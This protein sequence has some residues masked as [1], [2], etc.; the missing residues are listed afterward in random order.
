MLRVVIQFWVLAVFKMRPLILLT[1]F[2]QLITFAQST[3]AQ[4]THELAPV[5]VQSELQDED[6]NSAHL[7]ISRQEIEATKK[8]NLNAL[9]RGQNGVLLSQT[10]ASTATGITIGGASGGLGL[11]TLD[12]VPL[13]ATVTSAYSLHH[14]LSDFVDRI[15]IQR[16]SSAQ[17]S[18][19]RTL[20]GA[21]HLDSRELK[22]SEGYA[23]FEAGNY[24]AVRGGLGKGWQTPVGD[25][26]T[27]L[28]RQEITDGYSQASP[29]KGNSESDNFQLNTGL[30][31][32]R[33]TYNKGQ[34]DA[35]LLYSRGREEFDGPGFL[36][37][38]RLGWMD[39]SKGLGYNQTW[40]AQGRIQHRLTGHWQ[41]SLQ[42]A[43]TRNRQDVYTSLLPYTFAAN[44][45]LL[46]WQNQHDLNQS[47]SEQWA[48]RLNWGVDLQQQ[49]GEAY[50]RLGN[51]MASLNT[52]SAYLQNQTRWQ[53]WQLDA[54]TRLEDYQYYGSQALF[55]AKLAWNVFDGVQLWVSGGTGSSPPAV[56]DR[57]NPMFGR[58]SLRPERVASVEVGGRWQLDKDTHYSLNFSHRDYQQLIVLQFDSPTGS[59]RADNVPKAEIWMLEAEGRHAWNDEWQTGFN[60]TFM[61]AQNSLTGLQVAIRPQHQGNLWQAWQ[62]T[63]K[64]QLRLELNVRDSFWFDRNNTQKNTPAP[65][66]NFVADYQAL[67][68]VDV[69]L[70]GENLNSEHS[71]EVYQFGYPGLTF[72]GGIKTHF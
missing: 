66:L 25:W 36:P 45:W 1:V 40:L 39:D 17:V 4:E 38:G 6:T 50:S 47:K 19:S 33:K 27:L 9:L 56:N 65:R 23:K 11:L 30:L 53:N 49:H 31:R 52:A 10:N 48:S 57:L 35:T 13:F 72:W 7:S 44:L 15:D 21:I 34:F 12:G 28:E 62:A 55:S 42:L 58:A 8:N 69:Y 41:S 37:G 18:S 16:G 54:E 68:N 29:A 26:T 61:D 5:M 63:P 71:P 2:L 20:G 14:L 60:Y 51:S 64:L 67:P 46:R 70:R 59:S 43:M 32:G 3:L 22:N 24:G